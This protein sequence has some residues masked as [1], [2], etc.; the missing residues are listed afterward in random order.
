VLIL[1]PIHRR[2]LSLELERTV[3]Q[4][5]AAEV[6]PGEE[7]YDLVAPMVAGLGLG[8]QQGRVDRRKSAEEMGYGEVSPTS[9]ASR[10]F[11]N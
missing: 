8:S 9:D 3:L 1:A 2:C 7:H 6:R 11:F 4:Y 5:M 10:K